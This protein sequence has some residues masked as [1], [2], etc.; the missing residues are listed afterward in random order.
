MADDIY[1][2]FKEYMADGSIDMDGDTFNI[3][4][5]DNSHSFNA[6]HTLLS[7]VIANEIT[8]VSGTGYTAN[9]EA[10]STTWVRAGD[11]LTFDAT[12]VAWTASTFSAYYAVIYDDTPSDPLNPL[13]C[14]IDF[15]GAQTVTAGTFTVQ[16]NASGILTLT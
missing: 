12:D 7:D 13:V 16:F 1:P 9:G 4:L 5:L 2:S 3:I 14:Q 11:V 15:G 6:A 8:N 10:M